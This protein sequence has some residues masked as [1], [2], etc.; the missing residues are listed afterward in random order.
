MELV[1][2]SQES[3]VCGS[4]DGLKRER[5][6]YFGDGREEFEMDIGMWT[7]PAMREFQECG[8]GTSTLSV[9]DVDY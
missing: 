7:S 4:P 3:I 9:N 2:P 5:V 8:P 6:L 1:H